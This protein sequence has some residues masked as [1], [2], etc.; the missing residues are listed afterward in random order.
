MENGSGKGYFVHAQGL[1]ETKSVG[2]GTRVWAFAHILE[3]AVVGRECNICDGVFVESDVVIGDQTTIKSGV[4]LWDGVRLGNCVFVGPNATFTNDIF[5]RSKKHLASYPKTVVRD[6]ASI[7]ANATIMPGIQI[8]EGAMIGAGTVVLADVPARAVIVGNPGRVVGYA[9]AQPVSLGS[10]PESFAVKALEVAE[11]ADDRGRL[12]AF[13]FADLPFMPTRMFSVDLVRS[14]GARGGHAHRECAQI[15]T[16]SAGAVTC[17]LDDGTR[18]YEVVLKD[19]NRGVFVPPGVWVLLYGY[20][21]GAVLNV[22]ASHPYSAADYINDYS[23]F[24]KI[25]DQLT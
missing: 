2:L 23:E 25:K 15:I 16:A 1:C 21:E 4:Q 11:K 12:I 14:H 8:G 7:G 19:P 22:L 18:A 10:L 24:R 20:S 6:G 9:E 17:V 3:G 13:E 5:P